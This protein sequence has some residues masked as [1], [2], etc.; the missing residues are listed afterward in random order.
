MNVK[1]SANAAEVQ[2]QINNETKDTILKLKLEL[3][4]IFRHKIKTPEQVIDIYTKLE[5]YKLL[6]GVDYKI[7]FEENSIV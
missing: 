6:T 7:T 4:S 3:D 1:V 2:R 5:Y